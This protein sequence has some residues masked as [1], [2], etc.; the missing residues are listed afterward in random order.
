MPNQI[1]STVGVPCTFGVPSAV[2]V[3]CTVV[4]SS[5]PADYCD[6]VVIRKVVPLITVTVLVIRNPLRLITVSVW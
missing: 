4:V 5:N 2:G 3:P 1:P 6:R